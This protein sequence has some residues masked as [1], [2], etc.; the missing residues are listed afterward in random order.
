V[1]DSGIGPENRNKLKSIVD[2]REN[3]TIEFIELDAEKIFGALKTFGHVR[4]TA[5]ARMLIPWLKPDIDRAIY[6]DGDVIALRDISALFGEDMGG[7]PLA[8]MKCL[9][10]SGNTEVLKKIRDGVDLSPGHIY[11]N[12]GVLLIDCAKWR[13]NKNLPREFFDIDVKYPDKYCADQCT[14]NKYFENNYKLLPSKYNVTVTS[15]NYY[16]DRAERKDALKN[17]AIRHFIGPRKPCAECCGETFSDKNSYF[18]WWG[19]AAKTPFYHEF[20]IRLIRGMNASVPQPESGCQMWIHL[21][22]I[23]PIARLRLHSGG[24]RILWLFGVIPILKIK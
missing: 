7:F 10:I 16:S 9:E 6:V 13:A 5:Y 19:F 17:M 18:K 22:G 23:I 21:F 4:L 1:I 8:A 14:L 24:R 3:I 15:E 2:G 12:S 20:L 11:F